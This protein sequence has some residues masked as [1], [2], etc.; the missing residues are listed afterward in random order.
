MFFIYHTSIPET[1]HSQ[2]VD[3][4]GDGDGQQKVSP[5]AHPAAMIQTHFSPAQVSTHTN[6]DTTPP[7]PPTVTGDVTWRMHT[8]NS[9]EKEEIS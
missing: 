1:V 5:H 3:E 9:I 6:K 8:H 7:V 2:D 4:D